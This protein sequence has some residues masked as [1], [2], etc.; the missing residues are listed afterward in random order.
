MTGACGCCYVCF[1]NRQRQCVTSMCVTGRARPCDMCADACPSVTH[2]NM[3]YSERES[4]KECDGHSWSTRMCQMGKTNTRRQV[5]ICDRRCQH[6]QETC[7]WPRLM[8]AATERRVC[9]S[10]RHGGGL[11]VPALTNVPGPLVCPRDT[12]QRCECRDSGAEHVSK[13]EELGM[14][15]L[16][17]CYTASPRHGTA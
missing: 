13:A 12:R 4:G 16:V 5:C 6:P 9:V 7:S 8:S 14:A 11:S 3:A 17:P 2:K 10:V 1:R 15:S